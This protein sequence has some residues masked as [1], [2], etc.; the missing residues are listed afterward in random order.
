MSAKRSEPMHPYWVIYFVFLGVCFVVALVFVLGSGYWVPFL[1]ISGVIVVATSWGWW[2]AE[3]RPRPEPL[4]LTDDLPSDP[5][6]R[7]AA[8]E[9]IQAAGRESGLSERL[10]RVL[11]GVMAWVILPVMV[12]VLGVGIVNWILEGA[13][14]GPVIRVAI[15]VGGLLIY[16]FAIRWLAPGFARVLTTQFDPPRVPRGGRS[17][18]GSGSRELSDEEVR[19]FLLC[20][21]P[22]AIHDRRISRVMFSASAFA[23]PLFVIMALLGFLADWGIVAAERA[24]GWES[25][26]YWVICGVMVIWCVVWVL[27]STDPARRASLRRSNELLYGDAEGESRVESGG[28][29]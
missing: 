27:N 13:S 11:L 29:A 23:M 20:W 19:E 4:E 5:A 15:L 24:D 17:V 6:V 2:R 16:M 7:L 1:A 10:S 12:A 28:E 8:V 26:L 22:Q 14:L 3:L 21:T 25:A 18:E 9:R